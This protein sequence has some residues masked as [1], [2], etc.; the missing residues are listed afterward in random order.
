MRVSIT[1]VVRFIIQ[2]VSFCQFRYKNKTVDVEHRSSLFWYIYAS[3]N[4]Q[5]LT[6]IESIDD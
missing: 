6:I 1:Q 5:S 2:I 4:F 3:I